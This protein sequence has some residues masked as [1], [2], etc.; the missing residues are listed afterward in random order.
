MSRI[1]LALLIDLLCT[2]CH[3]AGDFRQLAC[4]VDKRLELAII[5]LDNDPAYARNPRFNVQFDRRGVALRLPPEFYA[6]AWD[7]IDEITTVFPSKKAGWGI[8]RVRVHESGRQYIQTVGNI[9]RSCWD[10]TSALL[11]DHIVAQG[12][13]VKVLE[14]N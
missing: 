14:V 1:I 2:S 10:A 9:G 7:D 5:W 11:R 3:A 4:N 12:K 8:L 6:P 13:R